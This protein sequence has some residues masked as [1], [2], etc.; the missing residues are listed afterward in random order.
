MQRRHLEEAERHVWGGEQTI[1]AQEKHI[2]R[3]ERE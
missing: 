2:E 1:C 3:L